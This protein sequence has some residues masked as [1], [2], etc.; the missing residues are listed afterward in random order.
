[1]FQGYDKTNV[2]FLSCY[3]LDNYQSLSQLIREVKTKNE[4]FQF[5]GM[6]TANLN[7]VNYIFLGT[8]GIDETLCR[9]EY[10]VNSHQR[11]RLILGLRWADLIM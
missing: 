3:L 1:M 10:V 8:I 6:L 11:N 9:A 4:E 7:V 2:I 5:L